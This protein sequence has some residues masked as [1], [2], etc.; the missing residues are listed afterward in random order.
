MET[1]LFKST[2]IYGLMN[3]GKRYLIITLLIILI[4]FI[5][6]KPNLILPGKLL[7]EI[8]KMKYRLGDHGDYHTGLESTIYFLEGAIRKGV[9]E[10]KV[11]D[12]LSTCYLLSGKNKDAERVFTLALK[13]Y[14]RDAEFYF[15]RGNARKKL[16]NF[17]SA[18]KDY[19]K[20]ISLDRNF[21]YIKDVYYDRGAMA[22]MLGDINEA[23]K[24]WHKAQKLAN[25]ELRS[26]EDYCQ[27]L[28]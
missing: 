11:F 12:I 27:S 26:Y 14:P 10:R 22:H 21:K 17:K 20:L 7:Y 2:Y 6:F 5:F 4:G 16:S 19:D 8:G 24:D 13:H 18:Y 3:N 9:A 28:K 25:Y 23:N 15:Y 1:R